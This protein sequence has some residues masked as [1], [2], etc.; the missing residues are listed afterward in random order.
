MSDVLLT[1]GWVR[2]SYSA[3]R[4]LKKHDLNI[5]VSDSSS[6]GMCQFSRFSSGFKKYTSHYEDENMFISDILEICSSKEI[7]LILPAHNETEIIARHRHRFSEKLVA[8]IPDESHCKMFNNKSNAYDYVS[9]IGVPVPF[10]I[11]YTDPEIVSQVLKRKGVQKT[12]IK[13]LTGNSAKGVFYGKN[14]KHTQSVVKELIKKYKLT[15]SRYP[16]VEEYVE[17][18]GYGCSVLYSN[19]QFI[20]SFTHKRLREK[21]ETG[22]T[23]TFREAA[24]HEGIE[25]ATKIIFD[26]IGWNG[27]AMCE[28]KVCPKTGRFWFIEVNPRMWGSISL[29]IESGVQFPYLAWLCA[30]QGASKAI[31]YH[32]TCKVNKSWKARWLLGDIFI[33]LSKV[34]QLD[35]KSVWHILNEEKADSIDDFVWDDPFAFLGELLAYLKTAVSKRSTNASEKGMVG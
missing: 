28:F 25:T 29:A 30:N 14:P 6:I 2:S 35:F 26:S 3:L 7:K 16:Q 1:Y 17:G 10:R 13:L 34:F 9:N 12:V 8:M 22:G 11:K 18:E 27:L 24:D 23:S 31:D 21:I 32:A 4:N 15:P 33:V 19:G 20:T 5:I